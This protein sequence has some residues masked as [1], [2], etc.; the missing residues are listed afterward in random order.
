MTKVLVVSPPFYSHARPLAVLAGALA[1]FGVDVTFACIPQLKHL[2]G[3]NGIRFL[4]FEGATNRN[5]GNAQMDQA[6]DDQ[7]RLE[8]FLQAT[9][10]GAV[11]A[12]VRQARNRLADMFPNPPLI[13]QAIAR[14]CSDVDPDWCLTDQLSYSTTLAL[15]CLR[16]PFASVCIGHPSDIP[17]P[18][19]I[20]GVPDCWPPEVSIDELKLKE[21]REVAL[22]VDVEATMRFNSVIAANDRCVASV[23]S[24]LSFSS[25][26][27]RVFNYP[28]NLADYPSVSGRDLFM[29][30]C[31]SLSDKLSGEWRSRLKALSGFPKVLVSLGTFQWIHSDL[32]R[33]IVGGVLAAAPNAAVV[34]AAGPS[35][36]S[37]ADMGSEHVLIEEFV[38]QN[39]LLAEMD[40]IIH[41]GG[42][43]SFTE[44]LANSV[45]SIVAPFASDQFSVAYDVSRVGL[46]LVVDPNS[47][48]LRDDI[49]AAVNSIFR[50]DIA[51]NVSRVAAQ[52]R[53]RGPAWAAEVLCKRMG[54]VDIFF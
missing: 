42:N 21:L 6:A 12:L 38:P 8:M 53:A 44:A 15:H 36:L 49:T 1:R 30:H 47:R 7:H 35:K 18:G 10:V 37:L 5:L 17:A 46:G 52:V 23:A 14:I 28:A 54:Q 20:F 34:V 25:N 39:D 50:D 31:S 32:L 3:Q 43:N 26:Q 4:E 19:S 27:A 9:R 41:H 48:Y 24:A 16:I 33:I 40:L 51:A 13:R 22:Q 2:A 45:P 29:G 11:D